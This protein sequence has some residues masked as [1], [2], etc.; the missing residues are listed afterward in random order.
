MPGTRLSRVKAFCVHSHYQPDRAAQFPLVSNADISM[1]HADAATALDKLR[2]GLAG[3]LNLVIK[4][5]QREGSLCLAATCCVRRLDAVP[6]IQTWR[7][8][9]AN[10]TDVAYRYL[11]RIMEGDREETAKVRCRATSTHPAT[12]VDVRV[13]FSREP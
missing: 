10:P 8:N 13:C 4:P 9:T 12:Y 2:W 7:Q 3:M 5:V 6:A 1:S 11:C